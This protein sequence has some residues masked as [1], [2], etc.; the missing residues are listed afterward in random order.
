M[1]AQTKRRLISSTVRGR[2]T[3]TT[4]RKIDAIGLVV[5]VSD[6]VSIE[7]YRSVSSPRP[8]VRTFQSA[9]GTTITFLKL[10]DASGI[11]LC[12]IFI[13]NSKD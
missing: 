10:N 3:D 2:D 8:L 9:R 11:A 4:L 12:G 7:I 1:S 5:D 13:I 6:H